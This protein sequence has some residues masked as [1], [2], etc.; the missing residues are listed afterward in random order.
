ML[1]E[2]SDSGSGIAPEILK[3]IFEPFFT[4]KDTG[5][6]SGLGLSMVFGFV[7]QSGGH[8]TV[9]SELGRGTTFRIYLPYAEVR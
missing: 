2:F 3:N 1:I 5:Q 6:G 8:L 4:T 9:Y 7:K